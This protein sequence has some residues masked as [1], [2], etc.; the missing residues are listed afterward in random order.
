M[1]SQFPRQRLLDNHL[2]TP[3]RTCIRSMSFSFAA[4]SS[5]CS[6]MRYVVRARSCSTSRTFSTNSFSEGTISARCCCSNRSVISAWPRTR[7]GDV[8]YCKLLVREAH[9][10]IFFTIRTYHL[11]V[12]NE[13]KNI[14]GRVPYDVAP[15]YFVVITFTGWCPLT[16]PVSGDKIQDALDGLINL[17]LFI[18]VFFSLNNRKLRI[19]LMLSLPRKTNADFMARSAR[20][21]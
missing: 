2:R 15:L 10:L 20:E 4:A 8:F 9:V 7:A 19:L 16:T 13:D 12:L 1:T 17:S 5:I 3:D 11:L 6:C 18:D 21:S 14:L